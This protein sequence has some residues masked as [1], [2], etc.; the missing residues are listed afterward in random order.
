VVLVLKSA[1]PSFFSY[2]NTNKA[3]TLSVAGQLR[4][5]AE[6]LATADSDW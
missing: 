3:V 5:S 1:F 6:V 2:V 4:Q